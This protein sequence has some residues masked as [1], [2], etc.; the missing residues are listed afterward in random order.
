MLLIMLAQYANHPLVWWLKIF[1][2]LV[3]LTIIVLIIL[4][5]MGYGHRR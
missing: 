1:V 5:I 3:C 2:E 4:T